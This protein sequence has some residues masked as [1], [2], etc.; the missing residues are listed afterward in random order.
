MSV[1]VA[2]CLMLKNECKRIQTTLDSIDSVVDGIIVYDTGSTDNTVEIV[3]S[4]TSAP[5]HLL[6][7][8]FE[9]FAA[10]RNI[11][12][13]F[14]N[15]FK[16]QYDYFLLL[17]CN[18]E[19]QGDLKKELLEHP[20]A[21][22][23][24][25]PQVWQTDHL[26]KYYNIRVLRSGMDFKYVGSVHEYIET[27]KESILAKLE[28]TSI[29]QDRRQDD[30][31]SKNRWSRD[32]E[33]LNKEYS[34]NPT[35]PR[36]LFYLAQTYAC[37]KDI[38]NAYKYYKLRT[39]FKGFYEERFVAME[40]CGDYTKDEQEKI[41]WYLKAFELIERVEPLLK[42]AEIYKAKRKFYMSYLFTELACKLK[43]PTQCVLFVDKSAYDYK[44]W[45]LMGIV[46]YYAGK[47]KEGEEGCKKAIIAGNNVPLDASNLAFYINRN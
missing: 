23:F 44:R 24:L 13:E 1:K 18:D 5:V 32:I 27:P 6:E 20:T 17:D 2:A 28:N 16:D 19:L 4:F 34:D 33:I 22:H 14:A 40:R 21:G 39:T 10:S 12:L 30:D 38:D 11:L 43:F 15:T 45:H 7:G 31:K 9:N 36:T 8:E 35:D 3:K 25:V 42:I 37:L 26:N 47:F 41:V 29:F 46:G